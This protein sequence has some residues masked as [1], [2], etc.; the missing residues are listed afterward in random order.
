MVDIQN[1]R[2]YGVVVGLSLA[3]GMCGWWWFPFLESIQYPLLIVLVLLIGMPHGATDFL[4]FRRL[5]GLKL[6]RKQVLR[7]FICYLA[8]VLIYL[9]GWLLIPV[10]ALVLFLVISAYHFGQSNWYYLNLP[11]WIAT[12]VYLAWGGFVLGGALLWHW[13]ESSQ[14][15]AQLVGYAPTWS[16]VFMN[17]V[18]WMVLAGNL[19]LLLYLRL[20][21]RVTNQQMCREI[22]SLGVLSFLLLHTPLLVGFTIYFTLWHSL[23]SLLNQII[24]F[25]RQWPSFTLVTYYRQAIPYTLLAIVGLL[26][27]FLFQSMLFSNASLVSTFFILIACVTLPHIIL[28]EKSFS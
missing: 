14:V 4:L 13:E 10:S 7:F 23:G 15:V 9:L 1:N 24:F 22:V 2:L 17:Q 16:N 11:R 26:G 5:Q 12:I 27:L 8:A 21:D 25:R 6:S 20:T 19:L 28:I 3:F 18:Q